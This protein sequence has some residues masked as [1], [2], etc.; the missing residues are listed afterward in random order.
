MKMRFSRV[1]V[2]LSLALGYIASA[3]FA[4]PASAQI[5]EG[6][7]KYAATPQGFYFLM[8]SM[9]YASERC[10]FDLPDRLLDAMAKRAGV[11]KKMVTEQGG[12]LIREGM[13][14]S[15]EVAENMG[16]ENWCAGQLATMKTLREK[17]W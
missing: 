17:G 8:G 7:R 9:M 4:A 1:A 10:K 12:P 14:G 2:F 16:V 6:A 5:S 13:A 15:K 11:T 3:A